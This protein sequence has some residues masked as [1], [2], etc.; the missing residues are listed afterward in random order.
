MTLTAGE[1]AGRPV[2]GKPAHGGDLGAAEELFPGA[3]QPWIDLSTGINP[4]SY[5]LPALPAEAWT[6]LP[7]KAALDA[8]L[9]AARRA[10]RLPTTS[11]VIAAPGTQILIEM[12]PV[13]A[14]PG[15]KVAVLGPTYQEHGRAWARA[16]FAVTEG[17]DAGDADIVIVVNP[18]NPD[19]RIVPP[20]ALAEWGEALHRRGGFL[21]VDEAFADFTPEASLV[22]QRP[23]GT[24]IL[25]SFGKTYG[26]AGLRLGFAM[27]DA[28][29][30]A[31][32]ADRLGPWCVS[33]PALAAGAVALADTAWLEAARAAR[34]ADA[35]RLDGLIGRVG[36][37][38]GGTA[39]Y[40]LLE[41]PDAPALF[42]RLGR[43]GLYVRR[44]ADRPRLL[45]FGLPP[46]EAAWQRLTDAL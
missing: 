12:L 46:D 35:A 10:Y 27:G 4:L 36:R 32:L 7:S 21:V 44:F 26:L 25:R 24:V 6:R 17:P 42:E 14:K 31:S 34:L 11:A 5:P 39:L 30:M 40:R 38:V 16:G 13:L 22:P 45:R 37:V 19:G 8:C 3:R 29:A 18:N 41:A 28:A 2:T 9:A 20:A 33:G 43:A 23:A 1:Q 15:A